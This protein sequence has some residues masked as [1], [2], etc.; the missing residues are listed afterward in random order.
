[1]SKENFILSVWEFFQLKLPTAD[2]SRDSLFEASLILYNLRNLLTDVCYII[3]FFINS[4]K[5]YTLPGL[6]KRGDLHAKMSFSL[7]GQF[8]QSLKCFFRPWKLEVRNFI[9]S[10]FWKSRRIW[11]QLKKLIWFWRFQIWR[12]A[13]AKI[14]LFFKLLFSLKYEIWTH[15]VP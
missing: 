14:S 1:M 12:R 2:F 4:Q 5:W 15:F 11:D 8:W 10:I 6:G 9:R 3:F 13:G 7:F